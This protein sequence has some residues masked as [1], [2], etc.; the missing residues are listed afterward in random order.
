M[1]HKAQ[2]PTRFDPAFV[3]NQCTAMP[4]A[5]YACR[6]TCLYPNRTSASSHSRAT[7]RCNRHSEPLQNLHSSLEL[8]TFQTRVTRLGSPP[9]IVLPT[10]RRNVVTDSSQNG[11]T[12]IVI[13]A[14]M[15]FRFHHWNHLKW[16]RTLQTS[17]YGLLLHLRNFFSLYKVDINIYIIRSGY[18]P[19]LTRRLSLQVGE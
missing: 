3:L 8:D 11:F 15:L 9:F 4:A 10:Y 16:N 13:E 14:L 7:K 5:V 12:V 2:A 1:L 17:K 6:I 19:F 18:K